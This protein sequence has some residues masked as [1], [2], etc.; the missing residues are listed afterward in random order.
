MPTD[1]RPIK[2]ETIT[3]DDYY[4]WTLQTKEGAE[5]AKKFRRAKATNF[6]LGFVLGVGALA[7][8]IAS[9]APQSASVYLVA[10]ECVA[11]TD[12]TIERWPSTAD[13]R[14]GPP[15]D[16]KMS[17]PIAPVA[18]INQVVT[19]GILAAVGLGVAYLLNKRMND[20][21][22]EGIAADLRRRRVE[23]FQAQR[24]ALFYRMHKRQ[25]GLTDEEIV[26]R[27]IFVTWGAISRVLGNTVGIVRPQEWAFP[28]TAPSRDALPRCVQDWVP[29]VPDFLVRVY[30]DL[31]DLGYP[32][33][34]INRFWVR[35]HVAM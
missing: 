21:A 9:F 26:S 31:T 22:E 10:H 32:P 2:I 28:T 33:L 13:G 15:Q 20:L 1:D 18:S 30:L 5:H 27:Y 17:L 8:L 29:R 11:E 25:F 16:M 14:C 12:A 23:F 34:Q 35:R 19:W 4:C 6:I 24:W 7:A 3:A